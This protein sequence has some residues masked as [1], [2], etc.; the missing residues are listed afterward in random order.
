MQN[1]QQVKHETHFNIQKIWSSCN[2]ISFASNIAGK[3]IYVCKLKIENKL[4]IG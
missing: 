1:S 3:V 4:D 2:T